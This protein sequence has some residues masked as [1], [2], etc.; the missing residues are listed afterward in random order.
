MRVW[1][2]R[3][4]G[5][6]LALLAGLPA[7]A[8]TRASTPVVAAYYA[9]GAPQV[10][11]PA[12]TARLTHIIYAFVPVCAE[13]LKDEAL[14][15]ACAG[16][17]P[18][19]LALPDTPGVRAD[20]AALARLKAA[21]PD[22]K[23]IASVGGWTMGDYPAIVRDPRRR[24]AFATSAAALTATHRQF[25]GVDIDWEY[26]G[27]GDAVRPLLTGDER[28]LEK[29]AH[30]ALV[31][32]TRVALDVAGAAQSRKL[33]LTTAVAG[34]PR[35]VDAIDWSGVQ[36][37]FD[38]VF[39]MTYDF[40]PERAFQQLGDYSGGGGP[41]GH[42]TNLFATKASGGQGADAMIMSLAEAG[43]PLSKM[44]IGVGFYGREWSSV[45]WMGPVGGVGGI[46]RFVGTPSWRDLKARSLKSHWDAAAGASYRTQG[47]TFVSLDDPRSIAA[48]G[49][50]ARRHGLAGIFA[51]Q[52]A[53]DDGSLVEAM[54]NSVAPGQP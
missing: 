5:L 41:P 28:E 30:A 10:L 42:H 26:P 27:G 40:T 11:T 23:I 29:R 48:K 21:R 51:W 22:L 2:R 17:A 49:E 35:A 50:W 38:L 54:A 52:L 9:G 4:L 43:V 34:H 53:Q 45:K 16:R 18:Y 44:A 25:D 1:T 12:A 31:H 3:L 32:E 39:V 47:D 36:A 13:V 19:S 33:L 6:A 14:K 24:H 7:A 15:T 8:Q 46:A 37:A 20:L